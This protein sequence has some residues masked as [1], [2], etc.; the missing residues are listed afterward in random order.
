MSIL[1]ELVALLFA[2]TIYTA[3]YIGEIVRSGIEG[4]S[5]GQSEAASALGLSRGQRLRL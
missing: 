3:A 5:K 1:P 2:L 4:V